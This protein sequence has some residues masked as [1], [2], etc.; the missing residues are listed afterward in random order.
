MR[1]APLLLSVLLLLAVAR[2]SAGAVDPPGFFANR[3]QFAAA[4]L[5]CAPA[6]DG[7]AWFLRDG[8][9]VDLPE[10][11]AGR[12]RRAIRIVFEGGG[13]RPV[14]EAE[15][16]SAVRANWFRGADPAGWV[17]G[18]PVAGALVYRGVW[19][20]VDLAFRFV[21]GALAWEARVAPGA[22][23]EAVR[24]RLEGGPEGTKRSAAGALGGLLP[25][26]AGDADPPL[27]QPTAAPLVW[28]T[29]LGG[30]FGEY[31][32]A[33]ALSPAGTVLVVGQSRSADFPVT[34]GAYDVT[35]GG[36]YDV[37]VACLDALG[38][39]LLW[40]TFLGGAGEDFAYA[41]ALDAQ[42]QPVIAGHTESP[43][44]PTTSGAFDRTR[45]GEG[46]CFAAKFAAGGGALLWSTLLGGVGD[47]VAADLAL[48][49]TGRVVLTGHTDS[50]DFPTTTGGF[51]RAFNG[52]NADAFVA[53]LGAT[54]GQL[55]WG[56]YLGGAYNDYGEAVSIAKDGSAV[57]AGNTG[58]S[59]FPTT[60]GA[61]DRAA[62]GSDD[63]FI[64][65]FAT[66]GGA[67]TWSTY[68]GGAGFDQCSDFVL[69]LADNALIA[70]TTYSSDFPTTAAAF[71]RSFAGS[72]DAFVSRV[73]VGGGRLLMSTFLGGGG[74]ESAWALAVDPL[75]AAIVV[76]E[77][78]STDFPATP[79]A[80]DM[81]FNGGA[82]DAFAL[83]LAPNGQVLSWCT[84]LG[85][86]GR[87]GGYAAL[88]MPGGD[89]LVAG[90]TESADFPVTALAY[91]RVANGQVEA[92]LTRFTQ[93]KPVG[94][95]PEPAAGAGPA[96]L[97]PAGAGAGGGAIVVRYRLE[98]R[99]E[100]RLR[101]YDARGRLVR[102]LARGPREA[103]EHAATWDGR[104]ARGRRAAS[105]AYVC[106][107]E[108][109]NS[110]ATDTIML[111]R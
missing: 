106:R 51:D 7:T 75:S 72:R 4:A 52:G 11:T 100:V 97:P 39:Q 3:G 60:A 92:F 76:G 50:A 82:T 20:G 71:D 12:Q 64:A 5:F 65:R 42:G 43:D 58:S 66:G 80:F 30:T 95:G 9:V 78:A 27:P 63:V 91:D 88:L 41:I 104:D 98:G 55:A 19:P 46:D 83:R 84:L 105:G 36:L 32:S 13:A 24:L 2:E 18:L 47:D 108:A 85:G 79:G 1:R 15:A 8:V 90:S 49:G 56:T 40:C 94:V 16:P 96:L 109:G 62:N 102:E 107:L 57:V 45:A 38:R 44:F 21:D 28:S 89:V 17:T 54:G 81:T 93:P 31:A 48:D 69:D 101:L 29:F 53:I 26:S 110:L 10:G 111:A 34:T 23:G 68:L 74:A 22:S 77:T 67:L 86:A 87:D 25:L 70:G 99:A 103:G 37:Y 59:D 35:P 6:G 61:L 73:D 14:V 33:L